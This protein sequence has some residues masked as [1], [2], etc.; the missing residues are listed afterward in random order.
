MVSLE[1]LMGSIKQQLDASVKTSVD[2]S[3]LLME[4]ALSA[5]LNAIDKGKL[6]H[7]NFILINKKFKINKFLELAY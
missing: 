1:A 2:A 6:F 7:K 5:K 3:M 4:Q